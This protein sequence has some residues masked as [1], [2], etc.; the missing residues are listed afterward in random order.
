MNISTNMFEEALGNCKTQQEVLF[1][2]ALLPE[3]G[4]KRGDGKVV[5]RDTLLVIAMGV[6]TGKMF[7][8]SA[9]RN[10]GFREKL[11]ELMEA[12]WD[13]NYKGDDHEILEIGSLKFCYS[14]EN[15]PHRFIFSD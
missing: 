7:P 13:G 12:K 4:I 11:V 8:E 15:D 10:F 3:D 14:R 9:S 6:F 5:T 1:L 2:I